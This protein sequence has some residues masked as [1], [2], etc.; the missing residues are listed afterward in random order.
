MV[1]EEPE[2]SLNES[3][4][5]VRH[6]VLERDASRHGAQDYVTIGR[7]PTAGDCDERLESLGER[8][9]RSYTCS[10]LRHRASPGWAETAS[11]FRRASEIARDGEAGAPSWQ[12]KK[13]TRK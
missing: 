7:S 12:K 9:L 4:P 11:G 13:A 10:C 3:Q 8:N 5:E 6:D 1:R 2:P